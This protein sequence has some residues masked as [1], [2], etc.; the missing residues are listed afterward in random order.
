MANEVSMSYPIPSLAT[1]YFVSRLPGNRMLKAGVAET[2]TPANWDTY[3]AAL[4]DASGTGFYEGN[5]TAGVAPG[6]SGVIEP[7]IK[8]GPARLPTDPLAGA[9]TPFVWDG[10][11]LL[12]ASAVYVGGQLL[13]LGDGV[14]AAYGANSLTPAASDTRPMAGFDGYA[15]QALD[16][17]LGTF[18]AS[19]I[20]T[21]A[22][23]G[24]YQMSAGWSPATPTAA[25]VA[26]SI[27]PAQSGSGGTAPTAQQN[28]SAVVAAMATA[29]V[30]S[31]AA[32]VTASPVTVAAGGI[33][34]A[35]IAANALANQTVLAVSTPVVATG[36]GGGSGGTDPLAVALGSYAAGT[37]GAALQKIG[38]PSTGTIAGDIA[39]VAGAGLSA[40]GTVS[41]VTGANSFTVSFP[42][43]APAAGETIGLLCCLTS[44]T[45][46]LGKQLV[47]GA[48]PVDSTHLTLAFAAPFASAPA[49]NDSVQVI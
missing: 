12:G 34:Q 30:G 38:T 17:S 32:P 11:R 20:I 21:G 41:A 29:P 5:F 31:V 15:I 33:A 3:A 44:G 46:K 9:P 14:A 2:T 6:T 1:L 7:H 8:A 16:P 45:Q 48:T 24:S 36:G 13:G 47:T 42:G 22:A 27:V 35:S 28:A 26:Y 43:G 19:S 25:Q 10:T 4:V 23:S 39:S 40:N 37:A 18:L 49:V